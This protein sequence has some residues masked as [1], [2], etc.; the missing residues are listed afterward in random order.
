MLKRE[1]LEHVGFVGSAWS[2]DA[3]SWKPFEEA[4]LLDSRMEL[5]T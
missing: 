5:D 2:C 4:S 1:T 3:E